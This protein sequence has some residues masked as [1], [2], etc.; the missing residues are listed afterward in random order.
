MHCSPTVLAGIAALAASIAAADDWPQWGGPQRD[1]VW[2]ESG[3]AAQLPP[4]DPRTG[5]LPRVWTAQIA[6][7][8]A[9]PAVADGRVFVA[10]R[11]AE[12]NL[13]RVLCFDAQSG[14]PLWK[15]Q[16][17][18]RYTISYPLGPR[19]TPTVDGERVYFLGAVGH[20]WCL[21]ARSG[22]V[23]WQKYLP[24]EAGTVVPE[25]GMAAAPLVD[26][27]QLIVLAGA[28]PGGTVISF[29]KLTGQERWR[30]LEENEP[31]YCPPVIFEIGGRRQ[32]I[33][34]HP[35]ALASLEP[36]N[37]QLLWEVPFVVGAGTSIV[38]P[39]LQ[40]NRLFVSC[41]FGGPLMIELDQ[42]GLNPRELWRTA[43]TNNEVK[44]DSIHAVMCT[45]IL[46]ESHV[47][48]VGGF[49]ELRCLEA[50]TGPMVWETLEATGPG[51]W[52]NAFLVPLQDRVV[53]CN[54]QGEI[55]F[56]R[57][58]ST[59]YQELSRAKL[60]EPTQPIAR[61]MAVWSHP[62]FA[63]RSV[64]AR[65]DGELIRVDLASD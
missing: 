9:G 23:I 53:I 8:Y 37:G 21:D 34:W 25:W 6:A 36:A 33:I 49:G 52:W 3:I 22:Q 61:R 5:M 55:I 30:A 51:R 39:R 26:G 44:N 41:F 63:M 17:E 40:G 60:I 29:D 57:I 38:T 35:R 58:S 54:E 28:K 45:P 7:G 48:G 10:D 13:E 11:I 65:N 32:L 47:F 2:R 19:T 56:A 64:F 14:K 1:L 20:L 42:N 62:A 31:G 59:G 46:T 27:Q 16:Y 4:A 18:A 43:T 24:D 12:Q 50:A 15:H